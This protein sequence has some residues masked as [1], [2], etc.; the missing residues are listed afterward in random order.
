MVGGAPPGQRRTDRGF[1]ERPAQTVGKDCGDL[2]LRGQRGLGKLVV[3]V[4]RNP[5]SSQCD[6]FNLV[7]CQHQRR[8]MKSSIK[9]V[10]DARLT[11]DWYTLADERR[12]IPIDCPTTGLQRFCE[13]SRCKRIRGIS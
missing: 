3:S 4:R 2:L 13:L 6:R 1:I 11:P 9:G 8:Q 5:L 12:N 7:Q 10:P